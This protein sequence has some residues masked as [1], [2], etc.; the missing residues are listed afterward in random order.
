MALKDLTQGDF[1]YLRSYSQDML[2]CQEKEFTKQINPSL[3]RAMYS[4]KTKYEEYEKEN[5]GNI[6]IDE[7]EVC[8][9][10]ES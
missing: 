10:R 5:F 6:Q 2:A 9:V 4:G 3:L 8:N 1:E 7:T